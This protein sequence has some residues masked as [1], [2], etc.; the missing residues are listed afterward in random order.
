MERLVAQA[1]Y[2][3]KKMRNVGIDCERKLVILQRMHCPSGVEPSG[4]AVLETYLSEPYI[5]A[6]IMEAGLCPGGCARDWSAR[7]QDI[8]RA[9]L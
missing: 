1:G 5:K 3:S 7:V 8:E 6:C 2:H 4:F 9:C